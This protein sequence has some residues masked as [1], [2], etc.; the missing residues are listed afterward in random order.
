MCGII[1]GFNTKNKKKIN[2]FIINQY[3]NQYGRGHEGFGIIRIN[4][5]QKIEID[6]ATEP[7][8][9][10]LDL[11]LKKSSMIIA[12]HRM[13]SSTNNLISQTHPMLVQNA[14]LKYDY[15]VIHNGIITNDKKLREKHIELGFEYKTEY[16]GSQYKSAYYQYQLESVLK[17]NDS[18]ALAIELALFIEKKITQTDIDNNAAF[19]ALQIN[20][21]TNK[22]NQVFFGHKG[23]P[24]NMFKKNNQLLL[25]S[26]GKGENLPE[27]IMYSF[28]I[29]DE[30]MKLTETPISLTKIKVI[31][32]TPIVNLIKT[33]TTQ[34]LL[35]EPK[36]IEDNTKTIEAYYKTSR[37]EYIKDLITNF[38]EITKEDNTIDIIE[39]DSEE[40]INAEKELIN[41]EIETFIEMQKQESTN[42]DTEY[43]TEGIKTHIIAIK[44]IIKHSQKRIDEISLDEAIAEKTALKNSTRNDEEP[45]RGIGFKTYETNEEIYPKEYL[46]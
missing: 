26:E 17:F 39:Y 18:E 44:A 2:D 40:A 3:E 46:S 41:E 11:Y 8:K 13:P 45:F 15:L 33:P 31:E 19:I 25:S 30:K 42:I 4:Q 28:S 29:K 14:I 10:L 32:D 12:H 38:K 20:K 6:R 7:T 23:N 24:L 27:D 43:I 37:E 22:A 16:M 36:I 5:N 9:F 1:A 21:K 35:L 34:Q